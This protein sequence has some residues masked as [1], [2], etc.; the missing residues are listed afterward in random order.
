MPEKSNNWPSVL[1]TPLPRLPLLLS[2]CNRQLALQ[3]LPAFLSSLESS[4][5]FSS[6]VFQKNENWIKDQ[7]SVIKRA[8]Y[9]WKACKQ[10]LFMFHG[11]SHPMNISAQ[12]RAGGKMSDHSLKSGGFK[13]TDKNAYWERFAS[14]NMEIFVTLECSFEKQGRIKDLGITVYT[15]RMFF[16]RKPYQVSL[17]TK[18]GFSSQSWDSQ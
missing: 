14:C 9:F 16:I 11:T 17:T 12:R 5:F 7:S 6:L 3:S 10:Q 15:E 18:T 2:I 13:V 4:A 1:E 8:E